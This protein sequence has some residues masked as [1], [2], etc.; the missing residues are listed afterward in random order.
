M[1]TDGP[2]AGHWQASGE[3]AANKGQLFHPEMISREQFD[4]HVSFEFCDMNKIHS[5]LKDYDF[6]WSSCAFEHLGSIE[7]GINFVLN[8]VEGCLKIGGIACHTTELNLSS[9]DDTLETGVTV[10]R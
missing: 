5:H 1:A 9:E 2:L 10:L 6:C 7:H 4:E 8:S 3:Y